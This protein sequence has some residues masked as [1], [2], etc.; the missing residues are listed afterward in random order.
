MYL[1]P[2]IGSMII[3][4]VVAAIAACGGLLF[5]FR[6]RIKA[7]FNKNKKTVDGEEKPEETGSAEPLA[8]QASKDESL[9]E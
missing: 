3:Q 4:F 9:S 5:A 7:F 1:D 2:G 8:A 6:A